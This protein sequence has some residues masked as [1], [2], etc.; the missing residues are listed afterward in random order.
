MEKALY[1]WLEDDA[2]KWL[3]V[4]DDVGQGEDYA[5]KGWFATCI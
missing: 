5:S 2:Q 3:S 4:S 1:I